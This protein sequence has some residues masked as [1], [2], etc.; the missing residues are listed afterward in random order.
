MDGKRIGKPL[1]RGAV[2]LAYEGGQRATNSLCFALPVV[3]W[4]LFLC[5]GGKKTAPNLAFSRKPHWAT[6]LLSRY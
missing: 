1:V 2:F 5:A 6:L 4:R 3:K